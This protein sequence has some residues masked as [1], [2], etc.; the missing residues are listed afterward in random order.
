MH[1]RLCD[2]QNVKPINIV[3]GRFR[4]AVYVPKSLS[5]S[6]K[7]KPAYFETLAAA[8]AFAD[9]MNARKRAKQKHSDQSAVIRWLEATGETD[10][11]E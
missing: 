2:R 4:Y 10:P 5:D 11:E 8:Q 1:L 9:E 6:G 7:R 3:N